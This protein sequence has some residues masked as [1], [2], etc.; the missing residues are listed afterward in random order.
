MSKRAFTEEE[1][2]LLSKNKFVKHV[3]DRGITY[4][5]EYKIYFLNEKKQGRSAYEI[6][7]SAGFDTELLG[8]KRITSFDS[9]ITRDGVEDRRPGNSGRPRLT[10]EQIE[11]KLKKKE[12][13]KEIKRLQRLERLERAREK[14]AQVKAKLK[15]KKTR[16]R[17]KQIERLKKKIEANKKREAEKKIREKARL[18]AKKQLEAKK[19]KEAREKLKEKKRRRLEKKLD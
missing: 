9:R 11:A 1:K 7:E 14:K 13:E 2:E 3:G 16:E 17:Q 19:R 6:F 10:E 12:Q 4:T 15:E 8:F 5:K 18:E